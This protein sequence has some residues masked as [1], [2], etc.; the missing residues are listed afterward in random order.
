MRLSPSGRG[1]VRPVIGSPGGHDARSLA[2]V[3]D[4]GAT[5]VVVDAAHADMAGRRS[6]LIS[7]TL[8]LSGRGGPTS[9]PG[10]L[11]RW[12]WAAPLPQTP[13]IHRRTKR[14]LAM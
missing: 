12:P 5:L 2:W 13:C 3:T 11:I 4:T 8:D 7:D 14:Q 10:H 6:L 1:G 9:P